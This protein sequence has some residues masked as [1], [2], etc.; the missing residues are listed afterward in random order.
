MYDIGLQFVV[1]CLAVAGHRSVGEMIMLALTSPIK[2][3]TAQ[4]NTG[5]AAVSANQPWCVP[6]Y[7]NYLVIIVLLRKKPCNWVLPFCNTL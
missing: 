4:T 3:S 2:A 5:S 6:R 1:L 7:E